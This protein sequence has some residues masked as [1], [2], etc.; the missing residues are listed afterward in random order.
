M[1]IRKYVVLFFFVLFVL[2]HYR[3]STDKDM[4]SGMRPDDALDGETLTFY[5]N[6]HYVPDPDP[7]YILWP[8]SSQ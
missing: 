1:R 8:M 4:F 3:D 2:V 7:I 5:D 6:R